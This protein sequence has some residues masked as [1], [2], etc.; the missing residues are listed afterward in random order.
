M[1]C[2]E[3]AQQGRRII[4]GAAPEA[5]GDGRQAHRPVGLPD[6]VG[7]R[8]DHV[9]EQLLGRAGLALSCAK[10][11]VETDDVDG[12]GDHQGGADQPADADQIAAGDGRQDDQRAAAV[13]CDVDGQRCA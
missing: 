1:S 7:G 9:A 13:A 3:L 5:T 10:A 4:A 12:D 6:P 2:Q 8:L 11:P